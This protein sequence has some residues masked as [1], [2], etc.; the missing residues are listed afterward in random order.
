M[1]ILC[2]CA[3]FDLGALLIVL[4]DKCMYYPRYRIVAAA[5]LGL[6]SSFSPSCRI[7]WTEA[8]P[9]C[10]YPRWQS[11]REREQK[12][13]LIYHSP[14]FAYSL[15]AYSHGAFQPCVAP[16]RVASPGVQ[17][18]PMYNRC[19]VIRISTSLLHMYIDCIYYII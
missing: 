4:S 18:P 12:C 13:I 5:L 9:S 6:S 7:V 14:F 15:V 1:C 16:R 11:A 17:H 19:A 2:R 8:R 3:T 10:A